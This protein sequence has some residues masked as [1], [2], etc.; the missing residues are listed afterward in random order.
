MQITGLTLDSRAVKAG[1]LFAALPGEKVHGRSFSQSALANGAVAILSDELDPTLDIPQLITA[2]PHLALA[3]MAAV[4]YPG[5]PKNLVAVTGTNGKSSVV[6]FLRQIWEMQGTKAASIG[7][8]G[9][10]TKTDQQ[11]LGYTTPDCVRLHQ[12]LAGLHKDGITDC[13]LE[14][15]SHGLVQR[16]LDGAQFTAAGFTNLTQDHFDYHNSFD[17]Y[18]QA[19]QR[20]FLK[21]LPKG[22]PVVINVDDSYGTRLADEC[23]AASLDV[24]RIGWAGREMKVIEVQPMVHG[25]RFQVRINGLER[26]INLPLVGEFQAANALLALGLVMQTGMTLN[27]GIKALEQL[28]GVRGRLELAATTKKQV[29]VFVDFAHTPDGLEKLLRSVRPHTRRDMILVFGC[30][31]DRDPSKRPLMAQIAATHADKVIVTDDNPRSEDPATIRASVLKELP[32]AIEQADRRTAIEQ[33][34]AMAQ[35]GDAILIAGK[36][37]EQGQIIGDKVLPFDDA[38]TA[39]DLVEAS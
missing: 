30:G 26:T 32:G 38:Q 25:Q 34:I 21:M 2:D 5:Q 24:W 3:K 39:R 22:A 4:F 28:A 35:N 16:R 18:Y 23:E 36:G 19:K 20:L 33:A 7:T 15:S 8:L 14:A 1:F 12:A 37:H 6:E 29:P 17:D 10:T 11:A 13:A 27:T 31:G 9:I